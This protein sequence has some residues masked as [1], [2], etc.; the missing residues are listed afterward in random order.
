[1]ILYVCYEDDYDS[2]YSKPKAVFDSL[3]KV[4]KWMSERIDGTY[5]V[6]ELNEERE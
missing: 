4:E 6:L 5:E 3:E 1:M 2:G